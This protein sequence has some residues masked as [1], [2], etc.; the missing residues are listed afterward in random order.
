MTASGKPVYLFA[1][2]QVLFWKERGQL[3]LESIRQ[4]IESP[5]PCAAYIGASNGDLPEFYSI[6][7][8][9]MEGIGIN[10]NRM[11]PSCPTEDDISFVDRA[12]LIMLAGGDVAL[13][14]SV[15][16]GNG[17]CDILI[18]R[19]HEG[20]V[21]MGVSAGAVQL[22]ILGWT[23]EGASA[24]NL[25]DTLR[26]VPFI[27]SAH[28]EGAEWENLKKAVHLMGEHACGIGIPSGGGM[29]YHA[30]HSME[31]VR[32]PLHEFSS[33]GEK[34]VHNLLLPSALNWHASSAETA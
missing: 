14:W 9:A 2:S 11:I 24:E 34:F 1:D 28:D 25:I 16:Q 26:I 33:N 19:Y 5:T 8:A 15:C 23:E 3:F 32:Y 21:L 31:A 6:F 17:L 20:A 22:G 7:E 18:R 30:D 13:G 4:R 27:V 10:D 12:N 29:V